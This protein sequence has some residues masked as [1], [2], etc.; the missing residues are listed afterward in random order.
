MPESITFAAR[1][2]AGFGTGVFCAAF[3][4]GGAMSPRAQPRGLL[5]TGKVF[6]ES[7][8]WLILLRGGVSARKARSTRQRRFS[9]KGG[10][11]WSYVCKCLSNAARINHFC[12]AT[13]CRVRDRG[14][15]RCAFLVGAMSPR[16]QPW[17]LL[18][19]GGSDDKPLL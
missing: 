17:G 11:K 16:A 12:G 10:V 15:L 2:E 4:P 6:Y 5:V 3:F 14:F 13:G 18:V 9:K 8:V 19:T 1:L 7:L